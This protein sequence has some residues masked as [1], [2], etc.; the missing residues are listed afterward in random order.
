MA[1]R[2]ITVALDDETIRH[3]AMLGDPIE[4]LARLADSAADGVRRPDRV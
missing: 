3:L 2:S 1:K 4:V